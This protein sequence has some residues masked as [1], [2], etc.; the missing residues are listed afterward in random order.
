LWG[1]NPTEALLNKS[2][3]GRTPFLPFLLNI[4]FRKYKNSNFCE[5][6]GHCKSTVKYVDGL[7]RNG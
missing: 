1:E 3:Q 4:F 6:N 7:V 2:S 5:R